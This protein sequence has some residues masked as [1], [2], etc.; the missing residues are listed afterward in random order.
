VATLVDEAT[1]DCDADDVA[2]AVDVSDAVDVQEGERGTG[3]TTIL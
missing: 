1:A 3:K 2:D